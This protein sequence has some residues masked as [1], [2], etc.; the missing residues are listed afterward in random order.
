MPD[1]HFQSHLATA[2]AAPDQSIIL[3]SLDAQA[4]LVSQTRII[5][6]RDLVLAAQSLLSQAQD[7][8]EDE[9]AETADDDLL[10]QVQAAL[11]CLPD[12]HADG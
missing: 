8:L 4:S 2:L 11:D 5:R 6:T 12:P 9:H 3:M 1:Q 7:L 10:E